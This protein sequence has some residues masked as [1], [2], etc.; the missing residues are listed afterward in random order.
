M[1]LLSRSVSIIY[2]SFSFFI[3]FVPPHKTIAFVSKYKVVRA[4]TSTQT[5]NKKK[6]TEKYHKF[7]IGLQKQN[8]TFLVCMPCY[9]YQG[10][11]ETDEREQRKNKEYPYKFKI[12]ICMKLVLNL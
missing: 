12:F 2:F 7:P 10:R 6:K 9:V 5:S 8:L 1:L 11:K 4:M 3:F